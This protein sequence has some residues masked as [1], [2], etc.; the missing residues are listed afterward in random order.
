MIKM[1]NTTLAKAG[2]YLAQRKPFRASNLMAVVE[3]VED[4][5]SIYVVFSYATAIYKEIDGFEVVNRLEERFSRSTSRHQG[6][7]K[8]ALGL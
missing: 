3:N 7:V 8:R 5:F 4:S 2:E 1:E 6:I